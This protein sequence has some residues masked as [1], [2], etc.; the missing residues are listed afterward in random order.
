MPC[1]QVTDVKLIKNNE[2]E[3]FWETL[4]KAMSVL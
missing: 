2:V 1:L 4:R 3:E